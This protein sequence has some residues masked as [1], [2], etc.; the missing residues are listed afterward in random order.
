MIK[1]GYIY[2]TI[3]LKKLVKKSLTID[4]MTLDRIFNKYSKLKYIEAKEFPN[5]I[6]IYKKDV[7]VFETT[8]INRLEIYPPFLD[9][10][11]NTS[12]IDEEIY[13]IAKYIIFKQKK[14]KYKILEVGYA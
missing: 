2:R 3:N 8:I 13:E 4:E 11:K 10:F 6:S 12:F 5:D 9:E 1:V 7:K 14:L